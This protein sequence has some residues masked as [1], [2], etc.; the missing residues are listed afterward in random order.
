MHKKACKFLSR[1]LPKA[2]FPITLITLLSLIA[3]AQ[4]DQQVNQRQQ[5]RDDASF[6]VSPSPPPGQRVRRITPLRSSDIPEGSRVSIIADLPL[7]GY[8]SYQNGARFFVVIPRADASPLPETFQGRAFTNARIEHRGG[9]VILSFDLEPRASARVE[10][11]FNRLDVIFTLPGDT[12]PELNNTLSAPPP[13]LASRTTGATSPTLR[14]PWVSR[15]PRLEDYLNGSAREAE[16]RITDFRQRAP[17]DGVPA[18]RETSAYLSY[19]DNNLYVVFVCKD[20]ANQIRAHMARREEIISDDFVGILLDTFHDRRRAY[21]FAANPLGIQLDGIN[22]EGQGDD[23]SFDTLWRSEGRLTADG[24]VVLIAIP[25]RSLRFSGNPTQTWGIALARSRP[26]NNEESYWPYITQRIQGFVPQFATLEG[27]ERIARGRNMQFMPYATFGSARVLETPFGGGAQAFRTSNDLRFGMDAKFVLRNA[28]TLDL[29][30]NPDFSQVESDEPQVTINRRFETFFPER[31]PFFIEN[32]GFFRTPE[33]LFFS[34]RI[35]DPLFGVRL[36]GKAGGWAIGA[37]AIDDRAPGQLLFSDDPLNRDRRAIAGVLRAQREFG[38]ESSFGFMMTS[39]DFAESS[40]RV[41]SFDTRLRLSPNW[42]FN[43]QIMRSYTRELDG[44]RPSGQAYFAEL[45]RSG[46]NFNYNARYTDRSPDFRATLGFIP[47][48]DIRQIEQFANYR[49]RPRSSR[50][51]SFGPNGFMLINWDRQGRVQDW[52][53]NAGFAVELTAQTSLEVGRS[54]S[55][56]LFQNQ[57]FRTHSTNLFFYTGRL[58]WL[59]LSASYNQGTAV[60]FFPSSGLEAFTANSRSGS[61]NLIFRP[62]SRLRFDQTYIYSGFVERAGGLRLADSFAA[63]SIFNNH[64]LRSKLNYQFTREISLRAILDYNAVLPNSSLIALERNKRLAA[65]F[66]FTYLLNPGTALYIGYTDIYEDLSVTS[67]APLALRRF[68]AP[69]FSTG[70]QFFIK[71]SYPF[72][73]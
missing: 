54:E 67:M 71:M 62:S 34:R 46:R 55:F 59:E 9:D 44:A 56:E 51:L 21:F 73:F 27:L 10:P 18:S 14:I 47:R 12:T 38:E 40:N 50:V 35:A 23:D 24:Y 37:L 25:F 22:T 69:T 20:E 13:S 28:F 66:L 15:P 26:G 31:R 60:N 63:A 45:M 39:Y 43:G 3:G 41:F 1:V 58:G 49:W 17:G 29:T 70:R 65:D 57:G 52:F 6:R 48:V 53:A 19:D 30:L 36:T 68:G 32:A 8:T 11:R 5:Q 16:A 2:S 33:S 42:V 72:R 64:I 4:E 7:T 61:F